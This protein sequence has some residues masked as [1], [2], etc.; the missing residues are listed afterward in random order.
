MFKFKLKKLKKKDR[1]KRGFLLST[2]RSSYTYLHQSN[3][4]CSRLYI[5]F[6]IS[7]NI[8]PWIFYKW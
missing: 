7:R 6:R 5:N 3:G 2:S 4:N 8:I 1:I